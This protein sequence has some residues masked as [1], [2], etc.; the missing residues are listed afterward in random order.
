MK[1]VLLRSNSFIRS[2]RRIIIRKDP[3]F[4]EDIRVALNLLAEDA[5]YPGLKTHKLK[6]KLEGSWSCSVGYDLR[7]I[8]EFV[9]HEGSEAILL[10]AIGTHQEVY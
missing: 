10:E 6:G 3:A 2:A 1:R 7:I 5:F 8:F 9:Q 4:A